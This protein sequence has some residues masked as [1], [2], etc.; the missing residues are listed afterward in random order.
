MDQRR[1]LHPSPSPG[2]TP[3]NPT[4]WQP[5]A[6]HSKHPVSWACKPST[7][8][9]SHPSSTRAGPSTTTHGADRWAMQKSIFEFPAALS[10]A[11]K[12]ASM[13][14]RMSSAAMPVSATAWAGCLAL[15]HLQH[16]H[17]RSNHTTLRTLRGPKLCQALN[18]TKSFAQ[19][20]PS[21]FKKC[22]QRC[23]NS[24]LGLI[25]ILI[26]IYY[27]GVHSLFAS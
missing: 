25:E 3:A 8:T 5:D 27:L 9:L 7:I 13:S 11:R 17:Q 6:P 10:H 23:L 15:L 21:G 19:G 16:H 18:T 12:H 20:R 2:H 4:A 14:T 22:G 26:V 1:A 24:S